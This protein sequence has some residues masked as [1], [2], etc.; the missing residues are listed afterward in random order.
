MSQNFK[1]V[2]NPKLWNK[3]VQSRNIQ[4]LKKNPKIQ[5]AKSNI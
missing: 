2:E 3:K 4:K 5:N 1:N